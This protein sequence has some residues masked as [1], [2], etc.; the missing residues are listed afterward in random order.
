MLVKNVKKS[1][2]TLCVVGL[3]ITMFSQPAWARVWFG[4]DMHPDEV[5]DNINIRPTYQ[6]DDDI[7]I[8]TSNFVDIRLDDVRYADKIVIKYNG[9]EYDMKYKG[10]RDEKDKDFY[11]DNFELKPGKQEME[12]KLYDL[13][14]N[15]G[16][17]YNQDYT[18]KEKIS[19]EINFVDVDAPGA[20]HH[21]TDISKLEGNKLS[22]FDGALVLE[23]GA[24]NSV[25][26]KSRQRIATDQHVTV[27]ISDSEYERPRYN[28]IPLSRMFEVSAY[29][30]RYS[31]LHDGKITLRYDGAPFGQG[32]NSLTVLRI[33]SN[34][35]KPMWSVFDNLG[36]TVD[37]VNKTITVPFSKDGFGFYGVFAV[38]GGFS[39]IT[40]T[41]G[42]VNWANTYV[43]T[44]YAK[45]IMS[46]LDPYSGSFGLVGWDGKETPISQGEFAAMLAKALDLPIHPQPTQ[47]TAYN[48]PYT[49]AG[50]GRY[51]EAAAAHGLTSGLVFVPHSYLTR[52]QAA[53]MVGK[54]ANLT[55][56]DKQDVIS[57]I[58]SKI[59]T[60][61][62]YISPWAQ[63]Y[64]YAT[65]RAKYFSGM[66][67]P[68]HKGRYI[69]S[70]HEHLTR[71]QAAK[72][73]YT[74]LK[75]N[76]KL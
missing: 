9:K 65:Y 62:D 18:H 28:Y 54:A 50:D 39:D 24:R 42:Y 22:A 41:G 55:V 13:Y 14:D 61:A 36:G 3:F 59:F 32:V 69:F 46:P 48:D 53:V 20:K 57:R 29:D 68:N 70:P 8:T 64:V 60:D 23:F 31:L 30:E 19:L 26:E 47:I 58:T 15:N 5:L 27:R 25:M 6:D 33:K 38:T 12:F 35:G 74:L 40:N 56:Y 10:Q 4:E 34:N 17:R 76:N 63:P 71:A 2:I 11:F 52:E 67:D 49:T 66:P 75:E 43:T 21:V 73:V 37:T 72:L 44:L 1:L 7:Y 45:G 51:I 16:N